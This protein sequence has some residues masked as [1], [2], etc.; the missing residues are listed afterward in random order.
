MHTLSYCSFYSCSFNS[1]YNCSLEATCVACLPLNVGF[2]KFFS[3]FQEDPVSTI[4]FCLIMFCMFEHLN[5]ESIQ[6][7][8][9]CYVCEKPQWLYWNAPCTRI[10]SYQLFW[11]VHSLLGV[12]YNIRFLVFISLSWKHTNCFIFFFLACSWLLLLYLKV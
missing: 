4:G 6:C 12:L 8:N 3:S 2:C 10:F 9:I 1:S 7:C 11:I 5:Y